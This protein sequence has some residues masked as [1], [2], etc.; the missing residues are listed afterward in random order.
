MSNKLVNFWKI[1]GIER[2]EYV[3]QETYFS[4]EGFK[5]KKYLY[6]KKRKKNTNIC[7]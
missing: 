4:E 6:D 3:L 2:I 7:L 1:H 5:E